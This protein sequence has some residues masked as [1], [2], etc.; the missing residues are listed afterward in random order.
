MTT[1]IIRRGTTVQ[2]C[3]VLTRDGRLVEVSLLRVSF[4]AYQIVVVPAI[5]QPLA[6][7]ID[8]RLNFAVDVYDLDTAQ[9]LVETIRGVIAGSTAID[10]G[11]NLQSI[12]IPTTEQKERNE[13]ASK[14][15]KK[16]KA[17]R[18]PKVANGVVGRHGKD[19]EKRLPEVGTAL[20]RTN[21][22]GVTVT[23]KVVATGVEYDGQVYAS[24]SGAARA[25][26]PKLG[27]KWASVDGYLFWG[28]KEVPKKKREPKP[29]SDS[30]G[31]K[32]SKKA[33]PTVAAA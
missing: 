25:A 17:K 8:F 30:E 27:Y 20:K 23:A 10:I 19:G 3:V 18:E 4:S 6:K 11:T 21:R 26:M 13:M 28:L 15:V 31:K 16:E 9:D 22:E 1:G 33:V 12:P 7:P 14:I 24:L 32:K 2:E 5:K 29:K